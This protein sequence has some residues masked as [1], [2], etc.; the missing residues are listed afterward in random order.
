MYLVQRLLSSKSLII[1]ISKNEFST[2]S[3]ALSK[4]SQL[5]KPNISTLTKHLKP[6][7]L[8]GKQRRDKLREQ[9][10]TN[11]PK[12]GRAPYVPVKKRLQ[13]I[14]TTTTIATNKNMNKKNNDMILPT[15]NI[16]ELTTILSN[17]TFADLG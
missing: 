14:E 3:V 5:R 1:Q 7:G 13:T 8:T 15:E 6:D 17:Q 12:S 4:Q 9:L 16:K 10:K 2:T 11:K